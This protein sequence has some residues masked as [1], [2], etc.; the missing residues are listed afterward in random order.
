MRLTGP[1]EYRRVFRHGRRNS[2]TFFTLVAAR[3]RDSRV[4]LGMAISRKAAGDA[5]QRNRL[6]RLVRESFRRRRL[7]LPALDVVVMA[8]PAAAAATNGRLLQ[9]LT[10]LWERLEHS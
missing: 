10:H 4:R 9:S 7:D 5:V 2:D 6:K 1:A 8:R 3:N